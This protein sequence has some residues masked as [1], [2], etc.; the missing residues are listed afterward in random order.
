MEI[1]FH[2]K[3]STLERTTRWTR[4]PAT[5][6]MKVTLK[7][8]PVT[9]PGR[10]LGQHTQEQLDNYALAQDVNIHEEPGWQ[11]CLWRSQPSLKTRNLGKGRGNRPW[12]KRPCQT[13]HHNSWSRQLKITWPVS[14]S[15][16]EGGYVLSAPK[17]P[18]RNQKE[19]REGSYFWDFPSMQRLQSTPCLEAGRQNGK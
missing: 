14:H 6:Y 13:V 9:S 12:N 8:Y 19:V 18:T 2:R 17:I 10:R 3:S 15:A 1:P 5:W 4:T 11:F 16:Q 7:T